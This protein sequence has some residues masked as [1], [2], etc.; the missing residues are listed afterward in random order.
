MIDR[1]YYWYHQAGGPKYV[2]ILQDLLRKSCKIPTVL[3]APLAEALK[4]L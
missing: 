3:A 4:T 2:G 1:R